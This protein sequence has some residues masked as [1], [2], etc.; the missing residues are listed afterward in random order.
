M[1]G[2]WLDGP[3]FG[4]ERVI[5]G[6]GEELKWTLSFDGK[7]FSLAVGTMILGISAQL[8]SLMESR[9]KTEVPSLP[10]LVRS[11]PENRHRQAT[12]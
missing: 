5:L 2:K 12:R 6:P 1:N 7:K 3:T 4:I 11:I 10:L 9:S 8:S